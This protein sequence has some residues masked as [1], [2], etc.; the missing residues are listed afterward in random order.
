MKKS[1][2]I[3]LEIKMYILTCCV[4][5]LVIPLGLLNIFNIKFIDR[6]LDFLIEEWFK[7]QKEYEQYFNS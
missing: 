7:L 5:C 2:A 1:T 4:L 3:Q 6:I